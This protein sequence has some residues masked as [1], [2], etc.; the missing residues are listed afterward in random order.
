MGKK[1]DITPARTL[2]AGSKQAIVPS[3]LVDDV[4]ESMALDPRPR[5]YLEGETA[6]EISRTVW[7]IFIHLCEEP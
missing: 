2:R 5:R 7:A 1:P 6:S 4:A 3:G